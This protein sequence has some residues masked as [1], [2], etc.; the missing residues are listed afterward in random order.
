MQGCRSHGTVCIYRFLSIDELRA[1]PSSPLAASGGRSVEQDANMRLPRNRDAPLEPVSSCT[2]GPRLEQHPSLPPEPTYHQTTL[3]CGQDGVDPRPPA[4]AS[5]HQSIRQ[6]F[7]YSSSISTHGS[8]EP[9]K[10]TPCPSAAAP[11]WQP[12]GEDALMPSSPPRASDV[13]DRRH[14]RPGQWAGRLLR[15]SLQQILHQCRLWYAHPP[16]LC[17]ESRADTLRPRQNIPYPS[18]LS[19]WCSS[20]SFSNFCVARG[21]CSNRRRLAPSPSS[22]RITRQMC[23]QLAALGARAHKSL[24]SLALPS[25]AACSFAWSPALLNVPGPASRYANAYLD[26]SSSC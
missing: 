11:S 9:Q 25:R 14:R 7:V 6:I 8:P 2:S 18:V 16:P 1:S 19:R 24:S 26:P 3:S 17:A 20:V 15:P 22:L 23:F 13:T 5:A 21:F 10:Q 12:S 4:P